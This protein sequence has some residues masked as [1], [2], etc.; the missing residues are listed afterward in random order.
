MIAEGSMGVSMLRYFDSLLKVRP[1][2][3]YDIFPGHRSRIHDLNYRIDELIEDYETKFETTKEFLSRDPM[4]IYELSRLIYGEYPDDSLVLALAETKDLVLVLEQ[5]GSAKL[6]E[7]EEVLH[8][9][10]D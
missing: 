2:A 5:R 4:T 6:L 10:E 8:A 7:I 3:S 1:Y 9:V